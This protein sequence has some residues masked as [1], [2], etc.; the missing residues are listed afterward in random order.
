MQTTEMTPSLQMNESEIV[1]Q[2]ARGGRERSGSFESLVIRLTEMLSYFNSC[3]HD[4]LVKKVF[5]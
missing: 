2:I 5:M 1:G 3:F 4:G